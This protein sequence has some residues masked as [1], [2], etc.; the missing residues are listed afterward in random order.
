MIKKVKKN[1]IIIL[2]LFT[3]FAVLLSYFLL[4]PY[5]K[6]QVNKQNDKIVEKNKEDDQLEQFRKEV[7]EAN[8]EV[9]DKAMM[10]VDN[11]SLQ[12]NVGPI[13]ENDYYK[14]DLHAPIQVIVYDDYDNELC[15]DYNSELEKMYN[16]FPDKIV[17]AYRNYPQKRNKVS[18][19]LAMAFE[20]AGAQGK[21]L[22]AREKLLDYEKEKKIYIEK[23]SSLIA[24]LNLK[25]DEFKKCV[26]KREYE[27]KIRKQIKEGD[28]LYIMGTPSTFINNQFLPGAY[29]FEDFT[30]SAGYHRE[31]LK[32]IVE[33]FLN[34]KQM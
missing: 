8:R 20:C 3:F 30:D 27:D 33:K 28:D 17:I 12:I 5:Y 13:S 16:E 14:G 9:L 29:H 25:E 23:I 7:V 22:L 21:A 10:E 31:G 18:F 11:N 15:S 32:T 34:P 24:D 26:D 2:V 6:Q 1:Q 4:A 19:D